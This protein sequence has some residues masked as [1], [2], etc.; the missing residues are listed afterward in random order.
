[1]TNDSHATT[2][3]LVGPTHPYTGGISQHTTRLALELE[4]RG[5]DVVVESW[6]NQYP[7]RLRPGTQR[8]PR[9]SPEIGI[10]GR[11]REKLT[12]WNIASWW[13]AGVRARSSTILVLSLPTPFHALIYRVLIAGAKRLPQIIVIGHNIVAHE[14]RVWD[15][16]QMKAILHHANQVIVHGDQEARE[17]LYLGVP[18][19][20]IS[21]LRLPSPWM[22]PELHDTSPYAAEAPTALFF[23]IIREYKGFD[24]LLDAMALVPGVR[25][26]AAGEI[27]SNEEEIHQRI[28]S[29]RLESRVSLENR[30]ISPTEF[31]ALFA[32]CDFVVLPYRSGTGSIVK[33]L[34]FAYGKPVVATTAGSISVGIID[35][36]NGALAQP[37]SAHSLA[38]ALRRALKPGVL[39][40]WTQAVR[41]Q[42]NEQDA[43]WERYCKAVLET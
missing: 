40:E 7:T 6:A 27:W 10:P 4:N 5:I 18:S 34:A 17:A 36:F 9:S 39:S 35:G 30:Y 29:H 42:R 25:L 28:R 19:G 16:P 8:V 24:V 26:V 41:E 38:G 11:I 15:K 12:W 13:A 33:D 31:P 32:S 22:N 23:G 37:G 1:M 20:K 3:T 21:Q 14:R 43:L 2:V